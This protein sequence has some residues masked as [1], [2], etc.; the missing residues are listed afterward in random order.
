MVKFRKYIILIIFPLLVGCW[1]DDVFLPEINEIITDT[2]EIEWRIKQN[3]WI[4][5]QMRHNYFWTDQLR[6]S[7]EYNYTLEPSQFFESMVVDEDRFSYCQPYDGYRPQTKGVNLNETVSL[8]TIYHSMGNKVGYFVYDNFATEADITDIV[9]KFNRVGID[10]LIID[11]RDN[12]GGYVATCNY[13]ASVIVPS[14]HLGE[15][16]CVYRYNRYLSEELLLETGS[17]LHKEFL[18]NDKVTASRNLGLNRVVFFVN[19]RSASCSELLINSLRPYMEVIVI[20]ETTVGKDVG[21]RGLYGLRYKYEL[22][23]ITFRTY[24]A[25]G[26]SVPMT[27]IV[28]DIS[29]PNV[30]G[31]P[32]KEIEDEI[33]KTAM[34]YLVE[35]PHN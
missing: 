4:Y 11:L 18:K 32:S 12:P 25:L 7:S 29:I 34:N 9:L 22:Y 16:F 20:G 3:I 21:M 8:D 14:E 24:N 6:D 30:S 28:P 27:G 2:E 1:E 15:I 13:L 35:N 31:P 5:K 23:P 10:E 17:S 19:R 33:L 26:D